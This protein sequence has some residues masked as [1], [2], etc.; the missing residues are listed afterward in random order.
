MAEDGELERFLDTRT[1]EKRLLDL[2]L[3]DKRIGRGIFKNSKKSKALTK[4]S[5]DV[6]KRNEMM[7]D[8]ASSGKKG[9]EDV[10]EE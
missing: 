3:S 4:V 9:E 7:M 8:K 2:Y 5:S 1:V 6:S 10:T